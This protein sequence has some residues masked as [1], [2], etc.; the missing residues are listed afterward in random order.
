MNNLS[1]QYRTGLVYESSSNDER[2][3][4]RFNYENRPD[5]FG[6]TGMAVAAAIVNNPAMRLEWVIRKSDALEHRSVPE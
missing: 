5:C 6:K 3:F 4:W 1:G 2:Q